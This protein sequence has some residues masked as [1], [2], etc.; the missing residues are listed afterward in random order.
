[1]AD[2]DLEIVI[3]DGSEQVLNYVGDNGA[4]L[5]NIPARNLTEVEV[6]H[7]GKVARDVLVEDAIERDL[8]KEVTRLE[9]LKPKQVLI[10]S[11]L[12]KDIK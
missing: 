2:N 6:L 11:G 3:V 7:Y 8:P 10:A 5:P 12:Y 1:M 9:K 4:F